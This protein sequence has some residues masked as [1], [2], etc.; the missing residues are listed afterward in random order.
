MDYFDAGAMFG[1]PNYQSDAVPAAVL[2]VRF[3]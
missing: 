3:A 2:P 1:K